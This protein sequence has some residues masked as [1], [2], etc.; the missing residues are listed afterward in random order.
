MVIEMWP[1]T[2]DRKH[3][4]VPTP[5]VIWEMSSTRGLQH[6]AL[7]VPIANGSS[8]DINPDCDLL[9]T[10]LEQHL[11]KDYDSVVEP[12]YQGTMWSA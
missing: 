5:N 8:S 1:I 4:V 2:Q 7:P 10:T 3:V 9:V 12:F 6:W 11:G